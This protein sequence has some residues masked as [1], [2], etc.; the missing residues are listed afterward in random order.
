MLLKMDTLARIKRGEVSVVY[1]RWRRPTVKTGGRLRTAVGELRIEEVRAVT[2]RAITAADAAAAGFESRRALFDRLGD[3]EGEIFRVAVRWD[4]PDQRIALAERDALS[5]DEMAEVLA[6]LRRM[7]ARA[8]EGPWTEKV[9]RLIETTPNVPARVLAS[10]LDC[11]RD[12][13]KPNVRKLKNL[14]LTISHDPGYS[15]SARGRA[16]LGQLRSTGPA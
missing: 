11:E 8:A 14:G 4:Q 10:R 2:R 1:R 7:D 9:L 12:W 15:L 3:G 6:R 5:D 16:V 13:L